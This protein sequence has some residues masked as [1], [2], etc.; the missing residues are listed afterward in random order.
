[1]KYKDFVENNKKY[2][3]KT[4]PA[5]LK[6]VLKNSKILEK[7]FAEKHPKANC[8]MRVTIKTVKDTQYY[9]VKAEGTMYAHGTNGSTTLDWKELVKLGCPSSK[10]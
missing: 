6:W 1:M 10:I 4:N 8:D 9:I 3:E 5:V 2:T 7:R